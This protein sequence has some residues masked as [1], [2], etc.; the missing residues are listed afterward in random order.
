MVVRIFERGG[1]IVGAVEWGP[2]RRDANA[3]VSEDSPS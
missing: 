3:A 1:I 2:T